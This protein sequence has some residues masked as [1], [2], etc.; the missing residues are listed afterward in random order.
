M[1]YRKVGKAINH[2]GTTLQV[3]V[4]SAEMSQT[5]VL[6]GKYFFW[7]MGIALLQWIGTSITDFATEDEQI[8]PANEQA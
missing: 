7:V 5:L 1:K 6:P 2:L 3:L 4:A 8:P